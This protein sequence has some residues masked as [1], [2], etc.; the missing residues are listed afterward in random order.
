MCDTFTR[1][2]RDFGTPADNFDEFWARFRVVLRSEMSGRNV[3]HQPPAFLGEEYAGYTNWQ[4]SVGF[5]DLAKDCYITAVLKRIDL[6]KGLLDHRASVAGAIRQNMKF[7]LI[8]CQRKANRTGYKLFKNVEKI[9]LEAIDDNLVSTSVPGRGKLRNGTV[10]QLGAGGGS[11]PVP[12]VDLERLID[13]SEAWIHVVR[14][15]AGPEGDA[16]AAA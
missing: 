1:H 15:I 12:R 13:S 4:D 5:D 14:T 7:F 3:W 10:L 9:L 16:Q 11:E 8:D 2:V 6:L